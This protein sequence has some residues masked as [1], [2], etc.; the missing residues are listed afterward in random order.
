MGYFETEQVYEDVYLLFVDAAGHSSVV[1]SNPRDRAHAGFSLL[2]A[3]VR[4]R[5]HFIQK[6][7]RCAHA[8]QW[9]WQGDGGLF[10]I[11]DPDESVARDTAIGVG[12]ALLRVDLPRLQDEFSLMKLEGE[13]H[14]RIALHKTTMR[15]L[16]EDKHGSIHSSD[17]NFAAHLQAMVPPDML[18]VSDTVYRIAGPYTEGFELVGSFE[19]HE[20]HLWSPSGAAGDAKR[21]W[22]AARGL[23]GSTTVF[24]YHERP[25]QHEKARLID[26]AAEEVIDLGTALRTCSNYL[27]TTERPSTFLDS[28]LRFLERGGAYRCFLMDPRSEDTRSVAKSRDEDLI[29]KIEG[30]LRG[31]ERFKQRH[32]SVTDRLI[33]CTMPSHPGMAAL[34]VD[35]ESPAALILYSPYLPTAPLQAAKARG[36]MPHYLASRVNRSLFDTISE[37]ILALT[38]HAEVVRIL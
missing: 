21:A 24:G 14:L 5:L 8:E 31:F 17:I 12:Q 15:Y 26:A 27:L 7:E 9:D 10:T 36:D 2:E 28:T 19:G 16:G 11:Y 23:E 13:L 32:G 3:R 37:T 34:A 4:E 30:S 38:S 22:L 33:V 20:I 35:L 1:R 25:S 18:A 6:E 29:E